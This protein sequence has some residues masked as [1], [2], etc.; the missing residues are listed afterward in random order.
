MA[1][2]PA[3][4]QNGAVIN[5][6]VTDPVTYLLYVLASK[7][8][9]LEDERSL[10]SGTALLD[11]TSH[12]GERIDSVL[13]RFDMARFEAQ[14]V[15]ADIHNFH[16]MATILL[17]AIGVSGQQV[18]SLLQPLGGRMPRNQLQFDTLFNHLRSMG[19]I[20][21]RSPN[22]IGNALNHSTRTLVTDTFHTQEGPSQQ[23]ATSSA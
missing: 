17:R 12:P 14:S 19:H 20:L 6:I 7:F 9:V 21:E 5:G 3:A 10:L 4:I 11:F 22:N 18:L 16:T 8:E 23:P 15:G 1:I 2:P 13:T